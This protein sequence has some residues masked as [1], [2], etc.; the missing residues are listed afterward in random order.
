M[1]FEASKLIPLGE[2]LHQMG[3][4]VLIPRLAAH[5]G[6]AEETKRDPTA[7]WQQQF[8]KWRTEI[9]G[10][11]VCMG[12]SLGGLLVTSEHLKGRLQCERFIL[13]APA[14]AARTSLSTVKFVEKIWPADWMIPSGIPD[15]YKHFTYLGLAPSFALVHILESF[16][17]QVQ[18]SWASTFP[19]GLVFIDP[20][21]EV[22][23]AKRVISL[24][25]ESFNDWQVREVKALD[26]PETHAFHLIVDEAHLGQAQW[27]LVIKEIQEFLRRPSHFNFGFLPLNPGR[28]AASELNES[29]TPRRM[30]ASKSD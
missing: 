14:L 21:D 29:S 1:N 23:D 18:S 26:L 28:P 15:N 6:D 7:I 22:V 12:Y 8:E 10:P 9:Q 11:L 27:R 5:R 2:V 3:Y 17:N 19:P 13:F 30:A 24:S 16:T 20:R 25:R 4:K